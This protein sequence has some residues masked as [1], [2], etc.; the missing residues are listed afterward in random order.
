MHFIMTHAKTLA[1]RIPSTDVAFANPR[2]LPTRAARPGPRL[3]PKVAKDLACDVPRALASALRRASPTSVSRDHTPLLFD[4]I[5]FTC[6]S[7]SPQSIHLLH[8]CSRHLISPRGLRSPNLQAADTVGRSVL[9]N[10]KE[11]RGRGITGAHDGGHDHLNATLVPPQ[12]HQ[13]R[14]RGRCPRC[15]VP[16]G[17]VCVGQIE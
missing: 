14:H 3:S 6:H 7:H 9:G 10:N 5:A 1:S 13:F 17:T 15:W 8:L 4:T 2:F 11:I 12:S 16:G